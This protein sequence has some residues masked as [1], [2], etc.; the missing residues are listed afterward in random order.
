MMHKKVYNDFARLIRSQK[1]KVTLLTPE[2]SKYAY[3]V[4]D[5]K[6][7]QIDSILESLVTL[8]QSDNPQF[9]AEKFIKACTI[10]TES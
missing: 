4:Q 9:N 10:D 1:H 5:A 8:F 6:N 3:V 2:E 7:K